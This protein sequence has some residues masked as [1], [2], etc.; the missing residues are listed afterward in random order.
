MVPEPRDFDAAFALAEF[1]REAADQIGARVVLEKITQ[2]PDCPSYFW[3]L[4]FNLETLES[5]WESAWQSLQKYLQAT[6][7]DWPRI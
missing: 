2:R 4:R 5:R 1:R 6:V 7:R 3:W